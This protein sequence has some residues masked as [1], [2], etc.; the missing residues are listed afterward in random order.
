MGEGKIR[1]L[2]EIYPKCPRQSARDSYKMFRL[3]ARRDRWYSNLKKK[4][5]E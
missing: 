5:V 4:V 3:W 1:T 2:K